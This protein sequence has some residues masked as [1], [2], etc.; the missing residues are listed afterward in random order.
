MG[1][2]MIFTLVGTLVS[3]MGQMAAAAAEKQAREDEA[4]WLERQATQER[5]K[6][7]IEMQE[8][9]YKYDQESAKLRT[10]G[11][12]SG[13]G[14][15]LEGNPGGLGLIAQKMAEREY[16]L[17]GMDW[18]SAEEKG[19]GN[20]WKA[21]AARQAGE[22]AMKAGRISALGTVLKFGAKSAGSWGGTGGSRVMDDIAY[23]D[24]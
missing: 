20:E 9:K 17:E 18:Y 10:L 23:D 24:A 15:M 11:A 3:A 16:F 13:G 19:K 1:L 14:G 21:A 4:K 22:A 12:A 8:R 7:S 2:E 5:A 6:G